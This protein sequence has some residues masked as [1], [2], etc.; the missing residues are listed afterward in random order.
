MIDIE[1]VRNAVFTE[2]A[3]QSAWIYQKFL[4]GQQI[5]NVEL[6]SARFFRHSKTLFEAVLVFNQRVKCIAPS[7]ITISGCCNALDKSKLESNSKTQR[8][9]FII[10]SKESR[11]EIEILEGAFQG[12]NLEFT[13]S[14]ITVN[15]PSVESMPTISTGMELKIKSEPNQK[16]TQSEN[17]K[18]IWMEEL[19]HMEDLYELEPDSKCN[20][21]K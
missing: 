6:L 11:F 8:F 15:G 19:V 14:K 16:F 3:D 10:D 17:P 13:S 2:P 9:E 18:D 21:F 20:H 7:S 1:L 12:S 5:N 4:F